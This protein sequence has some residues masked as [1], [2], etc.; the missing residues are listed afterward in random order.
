MSAPRRLRVPPEVAALLRGLH[1]ELKR[2]TRAGLERLVRDPGAGKA[3]HGELAGLWS[4]RLGRLR[5]VYREVPG[6]IE[7]VAVGPRERIY[8]ETLRLVRR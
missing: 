6:A 1:P 3:L 4:L 8:E 5:I 7:V 2:R